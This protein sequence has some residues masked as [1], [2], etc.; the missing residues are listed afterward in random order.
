MIVTPKNREELSCCLADAS[1]NGVRIETVNLWELSSIVEHK[2]EDMT[3]TVEAGTKLTVFQDELWRADN[4]CRSTR[5]TRPRLRSPLAICW[6]TT[7]RARI[8]LVTEQFAII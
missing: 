2:P 5:P 7:C 4:G 6:L 3:A 1:K 8:V